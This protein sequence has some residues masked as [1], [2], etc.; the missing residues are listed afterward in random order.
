MDNVQST[1]LG[2]EQVIFVCLLIGVPFA[3]YGLWK[4]YMGGRIAREGRKE[5]TQLKV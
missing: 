4:M 3:L 1:G 5:A 2:I